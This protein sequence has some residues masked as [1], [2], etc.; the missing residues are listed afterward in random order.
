[1]NLGLLRMLYYFINP[2]L[3]LVVF[4]EEVVLI[5][6]ECGYLFI[7]VGMKFK[8]RKDGMLKEVP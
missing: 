3:L 2:V 5:N 4:V 8:G 1:M 6:V 7:G